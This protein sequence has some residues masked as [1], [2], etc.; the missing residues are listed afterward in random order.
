M[1]DLVGQEL[2]R[3][4]SSAARRVATESWKLASAASVVTGTALAA[5]ALLVDRLYPE[6][7]AQTR[8]LAALG[9]VIRFVTVNE[10]WILVGIGAA[11]LFGIA[12][13]LGLPGVLLGRAIEEALKLAA[14]SWRLRS[15]RWIHDVG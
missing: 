8:A 4:D 15:G 14:F 6:L 11:W 7:A 13:G 3:R 12:L 2:G 1:H 5:T 10:A 9:L